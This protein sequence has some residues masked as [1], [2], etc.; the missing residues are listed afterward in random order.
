[1]G[2]P[3]V[4]PDLPMLRGIPGVWCSSSEEEFMVNIEAARN[5]PPEARELETF[6][7]DNSWQTRI[8]QLCR[9]CL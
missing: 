8:Q 2:K 9:A 7:K 4:V 3:V 5:H 1:M 6:L